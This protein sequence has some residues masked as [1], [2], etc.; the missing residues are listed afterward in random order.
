MAI[1]CGG[2]AFALFGRMA[3]A[4]GIDMVLRAVLGFFALVVMLYP[5]DQVAL[6]AA[7]VVALATVYGTYQHRHIC[8]ERRSAAEAAAA[9]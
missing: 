3:R 4:R 6:G 9:G 5:G 2:I 1:A 7:V 8:R